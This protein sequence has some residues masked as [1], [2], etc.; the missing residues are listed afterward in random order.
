MWRLSFV[1]EASKDHKVLSVDSNSFLCP[2]IVDEDLWRKVE[3]LLRALT[4][5]IENIAMNVV[6]R[7]LVWSVEY[8]V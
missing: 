5:H 2:A 6:P 8:N 7:K 3:E 4:D 1:E